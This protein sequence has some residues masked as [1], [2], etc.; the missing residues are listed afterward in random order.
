MV[1]ESEAK[2]QAKDESENE[3]NSGD[4]A[5]VKEQ[6]EEVVTPEGGDPPEGGAEP[7]L[8]PTPTVYIAT[9]LT[10][11]FFMG[12]YDFINS[13]S[14]PNQCS[15]TYMFEHPQYI[16]VDLPIE[17]GNEFSRYN[18]YVYSEG[19]LAEHLEKR[20]FDGIPV[21][22]IPGNAGSYKQVRSVASVA[23]RKSIDENKYKTHFDFFS[24]DFGEEMSA[25]YGSVLQD[26]SRF[27]Q[28]CISE[29]LKLYKADLPSEQDPEAT[30]L[31]PS[32]VLILG[33]SVG[34]LVAKSLFL[35]PKFESQSVNTI[36]TL[37][38]P[39]NPVFFI[40]SDLHTFYEDV[41]LFWSEHSEDKLKHVT[42]VS[43]GGGIRDT[44]V[45][46]DLTI[47]RSANLSLLSTSAPEVWVSADHKCIVWCKQLV[48]ALNRILFNLINPHTT[49]L[50]FD[51]DFR[52]KVLKHHLVDK[53]VNLNKIT[54]Q[55]ERVDTIQFDKEGTWMD[56]LKR[57]FVYK[58]TL[59]KKWQQ[60]LTDIHL[61][62]KTLDDP[63]H[64]QVTIDA[65]DL[66]IDD[67]VFACKATIIHK[68]TRMCETGDNLSHYSKLLP[69]KGQSRKSL[70]IS[71]K[72]LRVNHDYTHIVVVV[73]K[74]LV[75][76][77]V[78]IDVYNPKERNLDVALP[79]WISYFTGGQ[80]IV[81]KTIPQAVAYQLSLKGLSEMWQAYQITVIPREGKCKSKT[82]FG[83]AQFQT[84][85][86][87]DTTQTIL[88]FN[89]TNRLSVRL[90]TPVLL[91]KDGTPDTN[92]TANVTIYLN[93]SCVY[94]I[95]VRPSVPEMW[96]Q[97]VRVYYPMMFAFVAS[98]CLMTFSHQ[99]KL[100]K[101]KEPQ[102][103]SFITILSSQV[104]P[105]SGVMPCRLLA[106]LL[107]TA[108]VAQRIPVPTDF[109][110]LSESG[111]DFSMLP[112]ILFFIAMGLSMVLA[113]AAWFSVRRLGSILF[114]I[115]HKNIRHPTS[116]DETHFPKW[117][118]ILSFILVIIGSRLC[119]ALALCLGTF[120]QFVN[121]IRMYRD[122]MATQRENEDSTD[123][124]PGL[125]LSRINFHFT[126]GLL[127]VLATLL[128]TP[129]LM[130][131]T[132]NLEFGEFRLEK[133]PSQFAA[134]VI[135][136]SLPYLWGGRRP[137][138]NV[139]HY[140]QLSG[141]VQA[142][143][144][145]TLLYGCVTMYRI[146]YVFCLLF[147]CVSIHQMVANPRKDDE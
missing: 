94:S 136:L 49:Q 13:S 111:L 45:R 83:L 75:E 141:A 117:P 112:I 42:L 115:T 95:A 38:T 19:S 50:T 33:H 122:H 87:Q 82:H 15:M 105:M 18:L 84:S 96:G 69:S 78:N 23:L 123:A 127:W 12:V 77:R 116:F 68:G 58:R 92:F 71:L 65:V 17:M 143:G 129:S 114:I 108:A 79:R 85:L 22:F 98:A 55:D 138:L 76:V 44:Q 133:D 121:L 90:S 2:A 89:M 56:P 16:K 145:A 73:P 9:V 32:S 124:K 57:Q 130:A 97:I 47:H 54:R 26:Q 8:K 6:T 41:N 39:H 135:C 1:S 128:N 126:L 99:L 61:M 30:A 48:M 107:A 72:D 46:S 43:I 146:N 66:N 142:L 110:L 27:T 91:N 88:G 144:I 62:I 140:P 34:G 139:T 20:I 35:N 100:I 132:H 24:L 7:E 137:N 93:P 106:A 103:H 37:A 60:P 10:M 63:K 29:I 28:K 80:A 74:H 3:E 101:G 40:D 25:L 5:E 52:Y 4:E 31:P 81:E 11:C 109:A 59:N 64:D 14:E 102:V 21:L 119:G 53:S 113:S 134:L 104:S 125:S 118:F 147:L 120:F 51:K 131:W 86:A 70:T 36:I 67:W